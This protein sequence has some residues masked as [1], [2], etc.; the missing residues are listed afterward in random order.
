MARSVVWSRSLSKS[1]LARTASAF[2]SRWLIYI[3]IYMSECVFTQTYPNA[4]SRSPPDLRACY[5]CP[6]DFLEALERAP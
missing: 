1:T 6:F 4:L 5:P 3:V 2:Q